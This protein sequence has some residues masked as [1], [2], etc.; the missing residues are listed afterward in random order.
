MAIGDVG[1]VGK[2]VEVDEGALQQLG[3]GARAVLGVVPQGRLDE[4]VGRRK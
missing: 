3:Q 4:P 1:K 2:V